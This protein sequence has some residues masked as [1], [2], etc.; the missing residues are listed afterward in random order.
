MHKPVVILSNPQMG[1][2]IGAVARIMSNFGVEELRIVNPRDEWPNEKAYSMSAH[3]SFILDSAQ[4]YDNLNDAIADR[5][6]IY[7][8]ASLDRVMVK[9]VIAPWE[10]PQD[11]FESNKVGFLFGCEKSGLTNEELSLCDAMIRIPT[12]P[13]NHSLNIA[14]AVAVLLY[15]FMKMK[16]NGFMAAQE[17]TQECATKSEVGHLI[18]FLEK[19]LDDRHFFKSPQMKPTMMRNITN[20]FARGKFTAQ[21][22]NTFFGV[23]RAFLL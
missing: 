22:I 9:Q 1:E 12:S 3:G 21:E 4:I 2:N 20:M 11:I 15:E 7:G 5:T 18:S 13:L 17:E 10:M 14:Q 23:F 6:F 16:H 19:E 8:T